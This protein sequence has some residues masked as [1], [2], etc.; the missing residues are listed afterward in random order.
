[1][2][3]LARTTITSTYSPSTRA[4]SAMLSR[5]PKP[6]SLP[7]NSELPPRWAMPASKLTRV[8]NEGFSNSSAITRPGSRGSRSPFWYLLFRS[9]VIEKIRSISAAVRSAKVTGVAS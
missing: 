9:S 1:M 2:R 8:R 6:T 5:R 7:K 3:A 4:K